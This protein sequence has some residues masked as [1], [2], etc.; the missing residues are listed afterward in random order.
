MRILSRRFVS[1][2][3]SLFL[4]ILLIL[5]GVLA[6]IEMLVDF[7]RIVEGR[8]ASQRIRYL[9]LRIPALYLR[10]AIPLASLAAALLCVG[11]PAR[12]GEILALRACGIAPRR[13]ALPLL[14]AA[15]GL[16]IASLA[17]GEAW[18]PVA[19]RAL[20]RMEGTRRDPDAQRS[21]LWVRRGDALYLAEPADASARRLRKVRIFE[22]DGRG[23]LAR[24]I[25]AEAA[26]IDA[27]DRWR[28]SRPT[29]RRFDPTRPERPP[30]ILRPAELVLA[31]GGPGEIGYRPS[32][33]DSAS[34]V[35]LA[36]A[37]SA[38][39]PDAPRWRA[40]LHAR[41]AQPFSAALFALLA[42][43][44][45]LA[46][47]RTRGLALPALAALCAATLFRAAWSTAGRLAEAGLA[48]AAAAP[49][50]VLLAFAAPAAWLA[51]RS[52]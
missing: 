30:E 17:L 19:A 16:S 13:A 38:A 50:V 40:R 39:G 46:V 3:L 8:E 27:G 51:W 49:W 21:A 22:L 37:G 45:G 15:A 2:Y 35:E 24:S 28:I 26:R 10:D 43:P 32:G 4:T 5:L 23:R 6:A 14:V 9:A 11:L 33:T 25:V 48:T 47:E 20:D 1:S 18:L 52:R 29:L 31:A 36:R 44:L 34:L 41:V 42:L 12:S 7:D